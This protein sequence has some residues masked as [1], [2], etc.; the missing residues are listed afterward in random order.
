MPAD[1]ATLHDRLTELAWRERSAVGT[2]TIELPIG[3]AVV[4]EDL[5]MV[6]DQNMVWVREADT[7]ESVVHAVEELAADAGWVHRSI[8]ISDVVLADRLRDGLVAA[9]YSESRHVTMVLDD[10]VVV[11]EAGDDA[12]I[13]SVAEQRALGRALLAEE[14]WVTSDE[15]LDQFAEREQRL[16]AFAQISAV[17]APAVEPVSR[18]LVLLA[19]GVAEIDAVV[20]LSAVR[21]SGWSTA[22][23][24]RAIAFARSQQP[25]AVVL[26]A[27]AD[28]W[29]LQWY[30]RLGFA[31][32]G[33]GCQ[34][35]RWPPK[36]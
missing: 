18:C 36:D 23:M 3:L 26:V 35:R 21:G 13:S 31:D 1:P 11:A 34:F 14:P 2:R 4:T 30:R 24:R 10:G 15:V 25:D 19:D 33:V 28:D 29:P 16:A 12:V 7:A 27:D 5:P 9:G 22:V 8:E 6:Y 32:A 20:T 17:V